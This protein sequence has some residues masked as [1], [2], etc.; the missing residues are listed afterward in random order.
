[1]KKLII[2]LLIVI[3]SLG[4]SGIAYADTQD[5]S[6]KITG[7]VAL[8][9]PTALSNWVLTYDTATAPLTDENTT[10]DTS[11][12]ADANSHTAK[13]VANCPY[14]LTV[15]VCETAFPEGTTVDTKM[16][17]T[18]TATTTDLTETLELKYYT[19]ASAVTSG[20]S[21]TF[22]NL[23]DITTGDQTFLTAGTPDDGIDIVGIQFNQYTTATDPAYE[24]STQLNYQ[25]KLTWTA[26]TNI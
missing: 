12:P 18:N 22:A 4:L 23:A 24:G 1:M 26:S 19:S 14:N 9:V 7:S 20:S 21:T 13:I 8:T 17:S 3:L 15:K 10:N 6:A 16:T 11:A 25:I 5:I 2:A